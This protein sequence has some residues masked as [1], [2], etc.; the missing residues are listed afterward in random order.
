MPVRKKEAVSVLRILA[1]HGKSSK[2]G[3]DLDTRARP[4]ETKQKWGGW[5]TKEA[6]AR[7]DRKSVV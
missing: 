3:Q 5:E 4:S 1:L 6:L 7:E 2:S